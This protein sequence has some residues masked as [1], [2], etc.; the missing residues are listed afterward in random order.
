MLRTYNRL[1]HERPIAVNVTTG[2]LLG[3]LGD[4]FAQRLESRTAAVDCQHAFMAASWGV[5]FNGLLVPWWYRRLDAAFQGTSLAAVS[6]KTVADVAVMGLLSNAA[7]LAARG[8][9]FA[10]VCRSMP[11]VFLADCAVFLPYNMIAFGK[12]PPHIRPTT[13]ALVT[14]GWNTYLS[15]EAAQG[16][17]AAGGAVD[18][19][20]R[21]GG[22]GDHAA[23]VCVERAGSSRR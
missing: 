5:W 12:I 4:Y 8:E 23:A 9:P 18:D 7:G 15:H 17:A 2:S 10:E 20:A 21:G 1:L 13:T 16:R 14:L 22:D 6:C 3:A 19:T 11:S